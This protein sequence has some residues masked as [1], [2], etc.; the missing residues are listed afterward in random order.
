LKS[1]KYNYVAT[2]FYKVQYYFAL[3]IIIEIA[4]E[5]K[6]SKVQYYS[7]LFTLMSL[8][9]SILD[10]VTTYKQHHSHT[11][12]KFGNG[13]LVA[14]FLTVVIAITQGLG[15]ISTP[16]NVILGTPHISL[17]AHG[18]MLEGSINSTFVLCFN[19]DYNHDTQ[20]LVFF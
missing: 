11:I 19:V 3:L 14:P 13:N 16:W 10:H 17:K 2:T 7:T 18:S 5:Q 6:I 1:L 4:K 8:P 20:G 15:A 9:S 12:T